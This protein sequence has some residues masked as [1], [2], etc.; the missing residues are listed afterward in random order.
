[1]RGGA[2]CNQ[3][4]SPTL[5]NLICWGD[6][7]GEIYS[8]ANSYPSITYCCIQG[9]SSGGTGNISSDPLFV[10][11]LGA[12]G[13]AG[14]EDDDLRL[15][16]RSP[17][18][19]AGSNA[20]VRSGVTT[21]LDGNPRFVDDPAVA[22]TGSGSSPVVDMG[23]YEKQ[24]RSALIFY[25]DASA[26]PLGN[27]LSWGT[28]FNDLQA[29]LDMA[30][31]GD[32]IR[33]AQGIY[34]PSKQTN[35]SLPRTATFQLIAGTTMRG[36]FAGIASPE[37]DSRDLAV[38]GATLSGDIGTTGDNSDNCYHVLSAS[39]DMQNGAVDGFTITAGN[40]NGASPFNSG[41]GAFFSLVNNLAITNSLFSTNCADSR[42]GAM[43]NDRSSPTIVRCAFT[44]NTAVNAN[45]CGGMFNDNNASPSITDCTFS[46]N[47]GND[48]GGIYNF[49]YSSPAIT[50]CIFRGNVGNYGAGM[51]NYLYSSPTVVNCVFDANTAN[52]SGGGMYNQN[53]CSPAIANCT[54]AGNDATAHDGGG[55]YNYDAS[56]VV[57][58]C[59]FWGDTAGGAGPEICDS[60][61][62]TIVAY[63][64]VAG[65]YIGTG[66][67]SSDPLFVNPL[68]TDG[69]AGTEDDDLR[70]RAGSPCI[71]A[72]QNAAV[73][74]GVTTDLAGNPRFAEDP[75]A[76]NTGSGTAPIV[77]MGAY[78]GALRPVALG[79]SY[80][81]GSNEILSVSAAG[82]LI[83]DSD[84]LGTVLSAI[85][86]TDVG[87]GT[88]SLNSDGS[89]T[90]TPTTDY[91]GPDSFKYRAKNSLGDVSFI[92]T[93]SIDVAGLLTITQTSP[94]PGSVLAVAPSEIK[95]W[96]DLDVDPAAVNADTVKLVGSGPDRVFGT[97]DDIQITPSSLTATGNTLTLD[98]NGLLDPGQRY[99]VTVKSGTG[100]GGLVFGGSHRVI[101]PDQTCYRLTD[102]TVEAWVNLAS[103][104]S[105]Q[106]QIFI[107]D[108]DRPGYEPF[109]LRL[110][111]GGMAQFCI[112]TATNAE[113]I[114]N[115][116]WALTPGTWT[117][118]A[119]V[120]DS[121]TK[122]LRMYVDGQSRGSATA[123][124]V[125][126]QILTGGFPS[127]GIGDLSPPDCGPQFF[128]GSIRDVRIWGVART[129]TEIQ[130]SM[131]GGLI[132]SETG[133]VGYWPLNEGAGQI[134]H[135]LTTHANN[136]TLGI[137]AN[138]GSDDPSWLAGG[139]VLSSHG[140]VLDGEYS[141]TFPSGNGT[142]GG[143]FVVEFSVNA[144]PVADSKSI[145]THRNATVASTLA[146]SDADG[147]TLSYSIVAQ[148][149]HGALSGT[150]PNLNYAP[151]AGY[152]GSDSFTF[153]V[154]DG[155]AD[156]NTAAISIDV[157]NTVPAAAA[158]N[159]STHGGM[160]TEIVLSASDADSDT[161]SYSVVAQPQ[162][163]ALSGTAP[164]LSYTP[165][166]GYL[167]SD[168]F[169]FKANDG[170]VD[171]NT[172]TV[173]I[174][175]TNNAPVAADQNVSTH[176]ST[177]IDV[178]LSGS[179]SDGNPL[180]YSV[181]AQPQHGSLSGTVPNVTYTPVGNF[182]GTDSFMFTVNDGTCDSNTAT[183][184][185]QVTN[186]SPAAT[187]QQ[188][189]VHSGT[190][191]QMT[192]AGSDADNDALSF[193]VVTQPQHGTL[194]GTA[195]NLTYAPTGHFAGSDS[196]TFKVNDGITD[197]AAATVSITVANSAPTVTAGASLLAVPP[198]SA[199][200]FFASGND[201]DGDAITYAWNFGDGAT[202][203]EQNPS[204]S[205][206]SD[207]IYSPTVTVTDGAGAS[208]SSSVTITVSKAPTARLTTSDV[209]AFS[210]QA[211]TFD[212]SASTDPENQIASYSWNFGDGTPLGSGQV[213]SKVYDEP[214]TYAV[215]LTITDAAGVA[216]TIQRDIEVLPASEA[217][218][219]NAYVR[220]KVSWNRK[221]ENAD[222][223][224]LD[225]TVN[226]G[227]LVVGKGAA[228]A[229][230]VAG[231]RF[232]G[233]LDKKLRDT[234]HREAKWQV[235]AS[236]RGQPIGT[237]WIK[238][239]IK[240][241][242]LG[243]G[244]NQQGILG[245]GDPHD[246]VSADV[247]LKLEIAGRSFEIQIPSEFR[248]NAEG[249]KAKGTGSF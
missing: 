46:G 48:G 92:A 72:G 87:H 202:S 185:I 81:V 244:F 71:D 130:A 150:A 25:V 10:N 67:I 23:A 136:G 239:D 60:S 122:V 208:G 33:V 96:C 39:G 211:F 78:E 199:A 29:A 116:G 70:L 58:N 93:V 233:V 227:D 89:F 172:A 193:A 32:E 236:L 47:T 34:K 194:S 69:I 41:G 21:D 54:F 94:Q 82:V 192:L 162:H 79:D 228:V 77:D 117:H 186:R 177:V 146:V 128:N 215:T 100:T 245:N 63:T 75:D 222:T 216:T 178:V 129:Q 167:G 123:S 109:D 144:P 206:L 179:D 125:P 11:P 107:R 102:L 210:T 247:P 124:D 224:S 246:S 149:Q 187:G 184:S 127:L 147:D 24:N 31:P 169:T 13:I 91:V 112:A 132:G 189:S 182:S 55:M 134:V 137:D 37:P 97:S 170:L 151:N 226:V 119:G 35:P 207:G 219:F 191:K 120:F 221:T 61:S 188:L 181:V 204:H 108:D 240:K 16:P 142:A 104:P 59:I 230:E 164:N 229:F 85:L 64:C 88:L 49:N 43:Y 161:L 157:T 68:G 27:G 241:A 180:S 26:P 45:S 22:D 198:G 249:T 44:G 145:S 212:A 237:V 197:S 118:L 131:N 217:G 101:I 218:L 1:M 153:K 155:L 126:L 62:S 74:S 201:P 105:D 42:A 73:P 95:V 14:T 98:V 113:F 20:A 190:A 231:Q 57:T 158:K 238:A 165:A 163:G 196:F 53:G 148:P 6:S 154:N 171:S 248:F 18:I 19:D 90:Y 133:L 175:V 30:E 76:A 135:D 66:N 114:A 56:P 225:A 243:A 166:A 3:S 38:F 17:C 235:K 156:S 209:V 223:F 232:T 99:R 176:W 220:Y 200:S 110:A 80:V 214:G 15:K 138:P 28:A 2:I 140:K 174:D 50:N 8:D 143:D 51:F 205:Y 242:S 5:T 115:S 121:S 40:A 173:S 183:V 195:P 234:S 159:V 111:S 168:S 9:W 160:A 106:V 203:T 7:P 86:E 4:A 52:Y 141:G 36:G 84:P 12:D 65:G 103:L 213:I 83:N 139:G 152:V